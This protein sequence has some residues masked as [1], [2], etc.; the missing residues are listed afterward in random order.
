M[1]WLSIGQDAEESGVTQLVNKTHLQLIKPCFNKSR[2]ER[3]ISSKLPVPCC[4][5]GAWEGPAV[6]DKAKFIPE[7]GSFN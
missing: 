7:R 3:S 1:F 6:K 4:A 2:Q 5:P